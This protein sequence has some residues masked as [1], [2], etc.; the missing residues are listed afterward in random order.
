LI[1]NHFFMIEKILDRAFKMYLAPA[2]R[3]LSVNTST[4][5]EDRYAQFQKNSRRC[6]IDKNFDFAE[7]SEYLFD[8]NLLIGLGEVIKNE[9]GH[10]IVKVK[11]EDKIFYIKKY[12]IKNLLHGISRLFKRTRAYN[13]CV[14]TLWLNAAGIKT[15]KILLLLEKKGFL[16]SRDSF[17]V[18]EGIK[19][20]RLDRLLELNADLDVFPNIVAFF[21]RMNWIR[22]SHGDVKTSNFFLNETGL[23]TF[24]LDSSKRRFFKFS[25]EKAISKDKRRI[26]KSIKNHGR[27]HMKLS[28]TLLGN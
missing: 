15:A 6:F 13:S 28:K 3:N 18:T 26:L 21:K 2:L 12:R 4:S 25:H 9:K 27:L 8:E 24:D 17:L 7:L 23:I 19:G 14:S 5:N 22:F 1:T 10:L 16:G 11:K 20:E